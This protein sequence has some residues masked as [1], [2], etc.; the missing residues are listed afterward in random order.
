MRQG[1]CGGQHLTTWPP[2]ACDARWKT[3]PIAVLW[4]Y[5]MQLSVYHYILQRYYSGTASG[6]YIVGANPDNARESLVD[7][8]PVMDAAAAVLM[9]SC[10]VSMRRAAA[11]SACSAGACQT[12]RELSRHCVARPSGGGLILHSSCTHGSCVCCVFDP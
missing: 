6:M 2:E 8:V 4:H 12:T 3:F 9:E 5:R 11:C 10:G 7:A 1:R